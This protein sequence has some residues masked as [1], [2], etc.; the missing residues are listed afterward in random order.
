MSADSPIQQIEVDS[1]GAVR[2]R[3]DERLLVQE[4][5]DLLLAQALPPGSRALY[6]RLQQAIEQNPL[7][8]DIINA[9]ESLL[10]V[11]LES[12]RIR[13]MHGAHAE[14]AGAR[15]YARL[16]RGRLYK[17]S[18]DAANEVLRSLA[19][20]PVVE[21]QFQPS[22]AGSCSLSIDTGA[23]RIRITIRRSGLSVDTVEALV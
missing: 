18:V 21:A 6:E 1:S 2:L 15:L 20:Q 17:A 3:E 13:S 14:M 7:A 4:E 10:E 22:G 12:G 16:P 5:C 19:G 8:D 9:L 23:L 11:G